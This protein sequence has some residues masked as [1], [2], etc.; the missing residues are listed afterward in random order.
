MRRCHYRPTLVTAPAEAPVSLAEAKAWVR[1][2][3]DDE[4]TLIGALIA[5]ATAYLD[6]WS[7]VLGRCIVTQTWR[8]TFDDFAPVMRLPLPAASVTSVT[9]VDTAGTTRTVA[10]EV[11]ALREDAL[12]SF[13]EESPDADWPSADDRAEAVAVTFVA[14]YGAA[15]DVPAAIKL[16]MREMIAHWYANRETVA[17]GSSAE[18]PLTARHLLAPYRRVGV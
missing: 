1:V 10:A 11:Y 15:A 4:D 2:D 5:A 17:G 3:G 8:Q 9:Y 13:L 12:G 16:A 18:V 6:G 14:G 7:G